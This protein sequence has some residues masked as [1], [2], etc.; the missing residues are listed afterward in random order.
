MQTV[1]IKVKMECDG[2]E[3]KVKN[4]ISSMK[5]VKS[6][7]INIKESRVI[8]TGYVEQI[9]VL[10]KV[11]NT[12]KKEEIWPYVKYNLESYPYA[13]GIYDKKAPSGYVKKDPQALCF[14][15]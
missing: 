3:S 7:E 2:C 6:V 9:K 1:E 8:V 10:K 14:F 5:G 13:P 15:S 4:A 12:G 11:Q